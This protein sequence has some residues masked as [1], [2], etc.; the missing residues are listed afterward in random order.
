M[1]PTHG[2]RECQSVAHHQ[3]ELPLGRTPAVPRAECDLVLSGSFRRAAGNNPRLGIE[4]QR[5]RQVVGGEMNRPPARAWD[6]IQ[7]RARRARSVNAWPV[8]LRGFAW[9]RREDGFLRR[10]GGSRHQANSRDAR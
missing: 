3:F 7:K 8:D 1:V 5:I 4:L 2:G 10:C 9:L 6:P